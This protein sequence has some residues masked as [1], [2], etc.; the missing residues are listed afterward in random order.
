LFEERA[1]SLY[2]ANKFLAVVEDARFFSKKHGPIIAFWWNSSQPR[3]FLTK[4]N[5][6]S[7]R[8]NLAVMIAARD[9]AIQL[10]ETG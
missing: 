1:V 5:S 10:N 4:S 9:L 3:L 8:P 2:A 6:A 7:R